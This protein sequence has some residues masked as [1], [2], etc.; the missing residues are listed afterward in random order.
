ML[1]TLKDHLTHHLCFFLFTIKVTQQRE[2]FN[3]PN[4]AIPLYPTTF[5]IMLQK[6]IIFSS[7]IY[8]QHSETKLYSRLHHKS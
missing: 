6:T 8:Y 2:H 4:V 3:F 5:K 1:T 7:P